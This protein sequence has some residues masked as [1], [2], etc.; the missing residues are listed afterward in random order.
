MGIFDDE[1][2]DTDDYLEANDIESEDT[3]EYE[4][5]EVET[6][7]T[8]SEPQEEFYEEEPQQNNVPLNELLYER[9]RRQELEK[10]LDEQGNN[11][12]LINQRLQQSAQRQQAAQQRMQQQQQEEERPDEDEDPLGYANW[13][14]QQVE[15]QLTGLGQ[16]AKQGVDMHRSLAERNHQD[17]II[18]QSQSLQAEFVSKNP[19]YWDA[20]NHL[21][22]T[23][24]QELQSMGYQGQAIEQ[25]LDNEKSMIVQNSMT[26]DQNGQFSGW[27]QNPA[28]VVYNLA[29]QRGFAGQGAPAVSRQATDRVNRLAEGVRSAAGANTGRG[30]SSSPQNLESLAD[31]TDAEFDA[32]RR[33]NPGMLEA[34]LGG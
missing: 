23:R 7:E 24:R 26:Q 30:V 8:A 17:H 20:Y 5:E 3:E 1:V 21:I 11:L 2:V 16:M 9:R 34:M 25:V 32:F 12:A 33:Q 19:D 22:E 10:K 6:Y 18:S 4:E 28:E 31:M 27:R 13:R 29:R 15:K 14:I